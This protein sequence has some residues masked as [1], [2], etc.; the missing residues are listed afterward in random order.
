GALRCV[1]EVVVDDAVA[2]VV[3]PVANLGAPAHLVDLPVAVVV[4]F[5]A[6]RLLVLPRGRRVRALPTAGARATGAEPLRATPRVLAHRAV[7]RIVVDLAVA[8]VV[9]AVAD[10]G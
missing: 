7:R 4:L 8:V 5:V 2:V 3:L 1:G 9:L 6:G 10:L